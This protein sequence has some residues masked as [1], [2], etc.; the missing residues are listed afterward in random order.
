MES[1]LLISEL[2]HTGSL[3]LLYW[4]GL[5]LTLHL[6]HTHIVYADKDTQ[7]SP[8][9]KKTELKPNEPV[10]NQTV[11]YQEPSGARTL[12]DCGYKRAEHDPIRRSGH[13]AIH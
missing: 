1:Y 10:Q 6:S 4:T 5:E 13:R 9:L 8:F 2:T 12:V 7:V 3:T 11:T